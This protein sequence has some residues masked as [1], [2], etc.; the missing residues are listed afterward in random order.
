MRTPKMLKAKT[1]PTNDPKLAGIK[2]MT[3]LFIER[4]PAESA[5][6]EM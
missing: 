3:S 2:E 4:T 1:K 6:G 5:T